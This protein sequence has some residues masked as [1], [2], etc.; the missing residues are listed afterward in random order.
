MTTDREREQDSDA[1]PGIAAN[2]GGFEVRWRLL[3]LLVVQRTFAGEGDFASD[4][5]ICGRS[6]SIGA[7]GD[8]GARWE[9]LRRALTQSLEVSA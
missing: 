4:N 7:A 8:T 2:H 3:A 5:G 6:A 9:E 1:R